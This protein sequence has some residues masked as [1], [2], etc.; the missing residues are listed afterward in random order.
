M[1]GRGSGR[2]ARLVRL[3][4]VLAASFLAGTGPAAAAGATPVQDEGSYRY[5]S[6]WEQS[7]EGSWKYATKG[8]SVLRPEDGAVLGFRFALSEDSQDAAEPRG[9]T[10][11][12][13]ACADTD[14]RQGRKRIAVRIDFGTAAHAPDGETPP[15]SRTACARVPG[16]ASAAE[17]L[18]AV[19]EPLRYN[20]VALLCAV[21]GYPERGCG[22]QVRGGEQ[23]TEDGRPSGSAAAGKGDAGSGDGGAGAGAGGLGP[24]A[25]I[26]AGVAAVAVLAAAA[27]RQSRRRR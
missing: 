2:G 1:R 6:F 12:G 21:E 15:K 4:L 24:L 22:E 9:R 17:A 8:P 3:G 16:D 11:F 7:S 10:G 14:A 26:G 19:A 25:G 13:A 5:W 23:S 27:V 20:S 18:A